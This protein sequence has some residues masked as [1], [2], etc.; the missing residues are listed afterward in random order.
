MLKTDWLIFGAT[1][2][3]CSFALKKENCIILEEGCTLGS[4]FIANFNQ[5]EPKPFTAKT[6][7]GQKFLNLLK[8]NNFVSDSGEIYAFPVLLEFSK[9]VSYKDEIEIHFDTVVTSIEKENDGFL[10]EFSNCNGI[11]TIFANHIL[12]TTSKGALYQNK[13]DAYFSTVVENNGEIYNEITNLS[14]VFVPFD[15]DFTK[16]RENVLKKAKNLNAKIMML[17]NCLC[18]RNEV[19]PYEKDEI[20]Y[21]PSDGFYNPLFAFEG[22]VLLAEEL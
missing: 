10:V 15:T 22:G 8:E 20:N 7:D 6:N 13:R 19:K 16:T 1:F 2:L 9:L 14:Y 5:K 21:A 4:E 3:G 17:S 12:D 11:Q 18:Y